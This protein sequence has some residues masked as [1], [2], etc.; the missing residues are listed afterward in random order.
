MLFTGELLKQAERFTSEGLHPRLIAEGYEIAK[1]MVLEFLEAFKVT[2][3]N[4]YTDR[5]LLTNVVRTSLRTKLSAVRNTHNEKLS[6]ILN[7]PLLGRQF[8][9]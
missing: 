6:M 4:A 2:F 5:E 1:D 3:P 9:L 8:S 7:N